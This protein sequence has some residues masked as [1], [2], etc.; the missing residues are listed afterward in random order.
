VK[1][2]AAE[3]ESLVLQIADREAAILKSFTDDEIAG[4]DPK[5]KAATLRNLSTSKAL[6]ID[7][8]SSPRCV[9]ALPTSSKDATSTR[10]SAR[11]RD[12][13]ASTPRAQP[14]SHRRAPLQTHATQ[15]RPSLAPTHI[16][17]PRPCA[18]PYAEPSHACHVRMRECTSTHGQHELERA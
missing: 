14:R 6:Q 15:L 5:D 9:S 1:K 8:L 13:S 16:S 4:L 10:S 2:I 3:A 12:L 17:Y 18:S 7:K 11:W